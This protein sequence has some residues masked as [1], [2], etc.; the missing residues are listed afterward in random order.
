MACLDQRAGGLAGFDDDGGLRQS[1]YRRVALGEEMRPAAEVLPGVTDDGHLADDQVLVGDRMLQAASLS[2]I[3]FGHGRAQY[4]Y[5]ESARG[6]GG[7]MHGR[8][9]TP[10]KSRDD[11][12]AIRNQP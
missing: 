6:H 10:R 1:R 5:R 7:G 8:I 3:A 12:E 2:R 11:R 4:G 9:D